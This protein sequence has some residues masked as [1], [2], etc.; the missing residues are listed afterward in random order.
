MRAAFRE[1]LRR[2]VGDGTYRLRDV[3]QMLVKWR[4]IGRECEDQFPPRLARMVIRAGFF[5][6][7]CTFKDP[8][9]STAL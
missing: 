8:S 2:L 3:G 4:R 9:T 5:V 6:A 7:R 1:W